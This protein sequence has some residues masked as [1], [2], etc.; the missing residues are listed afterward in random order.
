[1][2]NTLI[3]A[4][5]IILILKEIIKMEMNINFSEISIL[6]FGT[7]ETARMKEKAAR[8]AAAERKM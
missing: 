6:L 1:M 4:L 8:A 3:T 5:I 7:E 2:V